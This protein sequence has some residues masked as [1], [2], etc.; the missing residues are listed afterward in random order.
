MKYALLTFFTSLGLLSFVPELGAA[1]SLFFLLASGI[2]LVVIA[3]D[4]KGALGLD[5]IGLFVLAFIAFVLPINAIMG[6]M[7]GMSANEIFRG[8]V[9]FLMLFFYVLL[10]QL[11]ENWISKLPNLI[12]LSCLVWAVQVVAFNFG[13]LTAVITGDIARLT[14]ASSAMLIPLGIVGFTFGLYS[15]RMPN[16]FRFPLVGLFLILIF[17]SGYRS[18]LLLAVAV[19]VFRFRTVYNPKAL[20]GLSILGIAASLYVLYNPDYFT[21]LIDRFNYSSGDTVRSLEIDFALNAFSQSPVF[22]NGAGFPVP[23][24]LT[25]PPS[26]QELFVDAFVPYIHNLTAYSLMAFG[27]FGTTILAIILIAPI[28]KNSAAIIRSKKSLTEACWV[29]AITLI[30]YFHVS[31]SFRQIQMMIVMTA[32]LAFLS[33]SRSSRFHE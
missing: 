10:Y 12:L 30:V 5:A 22:G 18:Q 14:Y 26:A 4:R 29:A 1:N 15:N 31:A 13:S 27:V 9:P 7:S 8:I 24:E 2:L 21:Y 3:Q 23:V 16:Y 11:P 32:L 20:F 6:I 25:R 33:K 19:A 28:A 17:V